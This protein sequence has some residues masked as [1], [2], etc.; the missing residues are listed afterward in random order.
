MAIE[1]LLS[2]IEKNRSTAERL[3]ATASRLEHQS[4][5]LARRFRYAH[6]TFA[7]SATIAAARKVL[8]TRGRGAH[9]PEEP[10]TH[11]QWSNPLHWPHRYARA[12]SEPLASH[13]LLRSLPSP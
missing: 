11:I 8:R 12:R 1:N 2:R 10:A 3:F 6:E 4:R 9:R 7:D 13:I 5:F